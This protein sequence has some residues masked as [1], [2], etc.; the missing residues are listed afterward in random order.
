MKIHCHDLDVA[1]HGFEI[2]RNYMFYSFAK[3]IWDDLNNS[4]ESPLLKLF[5]RELPL[6]TTFIITDIRI[7]SL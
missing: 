2:D 7:I 5:R 3:E 4:S 6:I 1:F